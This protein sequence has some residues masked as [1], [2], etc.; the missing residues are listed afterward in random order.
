GVVQFG[1][2][3]KVKIVRK[4]PDGTTQDTEYDV[5]EIINKGRIDKDPVLQPNDL[6][7]VPRKLI[8]F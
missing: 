1:N 5:G 2:E 6:I 3:H 4:Q 7:V 8:N